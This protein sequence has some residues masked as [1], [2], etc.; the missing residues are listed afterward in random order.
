VD[1]RD[2]NCLDK[3]LDRTQILNDHLQYRNHVKI[4]VEVEPIG[5]TFKVVLVDQ[6]STHLLGNYL[7]DSLKHILYA[8]TIQAS[9]AQ[10]QCD[11]SAFFLPPNIEITAVMS[12]EDLIARCSQIGSFEI[13][14]H[15]QRPSNGQSIRCDQES[16]M[17]VFPLTPTP[18]N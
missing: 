4:R 9:D 7:S 3:I 1:S 16:F 14:P 5:S 15:Y 13:A 10:S 6:A 12:C 11:P 17:Y 8:A 2:L 18:R